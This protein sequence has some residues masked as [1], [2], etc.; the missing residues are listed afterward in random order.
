M[1]WL[2]RLFDWLR[3]LLGGGASAPGPQPEPVPE[4]S[5][6]EPPGPPS[7]PEPEPGPLPEP[8]G[9]P[10]PPE[11]PPAP[12]EPEPLPT[13]GG[14]PPRITYHPEYNNC[15]GAWGSGAGWP[16]TFVTEVDVVAHRDTAS[17]NPFTTGD[18]CAL[19]F[20]EPGEH[21]ETHAPARDPNG[22]FFGGS[23]GYI[24][25]TPGSHELVHAGH[26][27]YQEGDTATK[28]T[29]GTGST[30]HQYD[31]YGQHRPFQATPSAW[32]DPCRVAYRL[33]QDVPP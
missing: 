33:T 8:N 25:I 17:D 32:S 26:V 5:P 11:G 14:F 7:P 12:P 6:P 2:R 4:P 30:L 27:V 9:P 28:P 22:N 15:R 19:V 29:C 24:R 21:P 3:R 10:G 31:A 1:S 18:L 23:R 16:R 13:Y 20:M